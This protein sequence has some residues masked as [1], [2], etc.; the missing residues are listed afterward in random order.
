MSPTRPITSESML[1]RAA[2]LLLVPSDPGLSRE[3]AHF[4]ASP[5]SDVGCDKSVQVRP[6]THFQDDDLI[7][8]RIGGFAQF[9][10]L[11]GGDCGRLIAPA[12]AHEGDDVGGILV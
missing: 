4:L 1:S 3:G 6:L 5:L 7:A 10:N 8:R 12:I 11:R 9:C 2:F